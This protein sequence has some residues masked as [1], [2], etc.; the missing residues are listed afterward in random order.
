ME[1][2]NWEK[3][4][5]PEECHFILN[6]LLNYQAKHKRLPRSLNTEDAE[7]FVALVK[8]ELEATKNKMEVEGEFKV[9]KVDEQTARNVALYAEAQ[10][11]PAC[12]FWGGIVT[13]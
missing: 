10:I 3:M 2:C 9:D 6:C 12:S 4:G 8:Q 7:E 5:R 11:S 13:Q 1:L